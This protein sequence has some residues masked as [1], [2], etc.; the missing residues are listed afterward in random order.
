MQ[1]QDV[2]P[3]TKIIFWW[4]VLVIYALI[5]FYIS[6][7]PLPEDLPISAYPLTD[8][9]VHFVEYFLFVLL[10]F[11]AFHGTNKRTFLVAIFISLIYAS[12]TEFYQ[13]YIP[14]RDPSIYDMGANSAGIF[15]GAFIRY[16]VLAVF[17]PN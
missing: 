15:L 12:F 17:H 5:L 6:S 9:A 11:K 13:T 2:N 8:K 10:A 1:S 3:K 4:A 14:E 7:R 16:R